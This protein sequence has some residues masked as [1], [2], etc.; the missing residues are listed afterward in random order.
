M[1]DD[2][3]DR[4]IPRTTRFAE[5]IR[6]IHAAQPA[7]NFAAE[8]DVLYFGTPEGLSAETIAR[9]AVLGWWVDEGNESM[10]F[11]T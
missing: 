11:F 7:A 10:A 9:L 8:H 5:G 1:S 2:P 4:T 3:V 6:I